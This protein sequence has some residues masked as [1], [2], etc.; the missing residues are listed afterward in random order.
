MKLSQVLAGA[1]GKLFVLCGQNYPVMLANH[2]L[3]LL[4]CCGL[5]A[6]FF[7]KFFF[8][9]FAAILFLQTGLD[10]VFHYRGNRAYLQDYF[11]NSPLAGQVGWMMPVITL[12]EVAAGVVSAAGAV[13]LFF[14]R[15]DWA[16]FG[17]MLAATSL[18]GLFFGQRLAKD[19]AGAATLVP[20]FLAAALG[21]FFCS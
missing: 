4:T 17:Q 2:A 11:K 9:A 1:F 8:A 7:L 16:W 15:S 13:A 18:L 3:F 20:Y 14:G 5:P 12:L 6:E 21:M 10:K 19:Y